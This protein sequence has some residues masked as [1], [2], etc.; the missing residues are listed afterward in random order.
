[1]ARSRN[2]KP[3]FFTNELLVALPFEYRLLFAGLWTLADREGRLENRPLRIKMALFPAD[4]VDCAHGLEALEAS[5]F[6]TFYEAN[7]VAYIAINEFSKHQNPH[8]K[9]VASVIPEPP[10]LGQPQASPGIPSVEGGGNRADSLIPDSSP[11]IPDSGG[12]A[13]RASRLP[14][15]FQIPT[16]WIEW[17][18]GAQPTWDAEHALGVG[19][20]FRDHWIAVPGGRGVKLDWEATWRNWVRREPPAKRTSRGTN[21]EQRNLAAVAD[22]S[23]Q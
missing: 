23:P 21:L 1:M 2:I 11:L 12:K 16:E 20:R 19:V 9:E 18:I 8:H 22:W 15:D 3:G 10:P 14:R 6:I 13:G 7:E 5:G 17:A 4:N